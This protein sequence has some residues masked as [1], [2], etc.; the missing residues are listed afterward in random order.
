MCLQPTIKEAIGIGKGHAFEIGEPLFQRL[1]NIH[2]TLMCLALK[3]KLDFQ[4]REGNLNFKGE[5]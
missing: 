5:K 1:V 2:Q 4:G 3:R